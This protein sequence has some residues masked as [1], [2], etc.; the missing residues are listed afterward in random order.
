[1]KIISLKNNLKNIITQA[2]RF[3]GKNI[4]LPILGNV[5]IES[6]GKKCSISATNLE[7]AMEA[8]FP[9]KAVQ[10][11]A[12]TVP[13]RILST[14]IQTIPEE[15]VTLEEKNNILSINSE[16]SKITING[17]PSKDFPIIPKV[18]GG[19]KLNS[20]F[21]SLF[22][23]LKS[24]IPAVSRSELKPEISGVL[25]KI[26]GKKIKLVATD[27]FRLAEKTLSLS[28]TEETKASFVVPVRTV[29][30]LARLFFEEGDEVTVNYSDNQV[31][32]EIGDQTITSRL[33]DGVFPEYGGIIPK[34]F[35]STA[36]MEKSELIQK[37]RAASVLSSKL[38]DIVLKFSGEELTVESSN[39]EL[40]S[41]SSK[42]KLK[43]FTGKPMNLS[44]N[45]RYLLD[46]LESI[47]D[48]EIFIGV[49]GESSPAL[50]RSQTDESLIYVL[51]PIRNI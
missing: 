29:E 26:E 9:C 17:N 30:E 5:L 18:K 49:S 15:N 47:P 35:E 51:M 28:S 46:G 21:L 2:E 40:G 23:G 32:F 3:T 33:I 48:E 36:F 13:A 7:M 44:F 4:N 25:F 1:M 16:N 10:E 39:S 43:K 19:K 8:S 45:F 6:K 11:G 50:L 41:M 24:V 20:S 34:N 27:T 12:V 31:V 37:I 22:D 38:N 14:V 42:I